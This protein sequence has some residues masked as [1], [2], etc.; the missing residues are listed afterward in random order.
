[1]PPVD[2]VKVVFGRPDIGKY[3]KDTFAT[4]SDSDTAGGGIGVG[5]RSTASVRDDYRTQGRLDKSQ[6]ISKAVLMRADSKLNFIKPPP[7]RKNQVG[8]PLLPLRHQR[9]RLPAHHT[10]PQQG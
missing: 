9:R 8:A 10:P 4:T 7:K 6:R 5:D 1:M 3:L 2:P